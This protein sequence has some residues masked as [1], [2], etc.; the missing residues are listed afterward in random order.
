VGIW[1]AK[2]LSASKIRSIVNAARVLWRD[3]VADRVAGGCSS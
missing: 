3:Q 1:L 2:G